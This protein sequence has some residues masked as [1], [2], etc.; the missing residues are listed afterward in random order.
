MSAETIITKIKEDTEKEVKDIL[1]DAKKESQQIIKQA[2]D[3]AHKQAENILQQASTEKE[4]IKRI[5]VSQAQQEAKRQ[6]MQAKEQIIEECF[7]SAIEQLKNLD[8]D[9]YSKMISSLIKKGA[10]NIPSDFIICI[11]KPL[12]AI[13]AKKL[14]IPVKGTI[15]SYG[16]IMLISED[17][18]INVDNTFEGI[19]KRKKDIIRIQ[20]GKLLFS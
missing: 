7:Q 9:S 16:G 6:L 4:N 17:G 11:S 5:Q 15:D 2:Q 18:R 3:E 19:M 13:I 14:N 20:V 10:A 1:L 8:D 12:D